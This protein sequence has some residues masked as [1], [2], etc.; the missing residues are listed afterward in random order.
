MHFLLALVMKSMSVLISVVLRRTQAC[1]FYQPFC[2]VSLFNHF[3]IEK[4]LSQNTNMGS[5]SSMQSLLSGGNFPVA[6]RWLRA[7]SPFNFFKIAS[8]E[9]RGIF[10]MFFRVWCCNAALNEQKLFRNGYYLQYH[11]TLWFAIVIHEGIPFLPVRTELSVFLWHFSF[12][13]NFLLNCYT[14]LNAT[15]LLSQCTFSN[16]IQINY[17]LCVSN[18]DKR[19][20]CFVDIEYCSVSL[21]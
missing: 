3:I 21:A 11:K 19:C 5:T 13:T 6:P 7:W 12:D 17:R 18:K 1:R 8:L 2:F 15:S 16:L 10:R 4:A 9:F 14:W 20:A